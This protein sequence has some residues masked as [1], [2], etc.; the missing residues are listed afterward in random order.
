[1]IDETTSLA[2]EHLRHI[3][4]TIE[5]VGDRLARVECLTAVSGHLAC[6][7]LAEASQTSEIDKG[8]QRLDR[9]ERRL[10]LVDDQ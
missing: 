2:L 5:V 9:V 7:L 3:R 4:A 1:M 10:E 6:R 8:P